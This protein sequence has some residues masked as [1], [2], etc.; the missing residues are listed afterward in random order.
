MAVPSDK[1]MNATGMSYMESFMAPPSHADQTCNNFV[2]ISINRDPSFNA[3]VRMSGA[4][5][6]YGWNEKT[7]FCRNT[8]DDVDEDSPLTRDTDIRMR[9][10]NA[11]KNDTAPSFGA[12]MLPPP[13]VSKKFVLY[14]SISDSNPSSKLKKPDNPQSEKPQGIDFRYLSENIAPPPHPVKEID[15]KRSD[16]YVLNRRS[17][18][19]S[20]RIAEIEAISNAADVLVSLIINII[21]R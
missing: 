13:S 12:V 21:L 2:E 6:V 16:N 1:L 7:R 11:T 5:T 4:T 20:A 19:V 18:S 10:S 14:E 9:D 3:S 8:S 17:T 15:Q